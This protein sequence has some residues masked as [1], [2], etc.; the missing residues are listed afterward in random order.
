MNIFTRAF[1]FM[2]RELLTAFRLSL[3]QILHR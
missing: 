2:M 3:P 1:V